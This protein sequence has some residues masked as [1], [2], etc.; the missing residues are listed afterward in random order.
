VVEELHRWIGYSD[1][2]SRGF[3][4]VCSCGWESRP[5]SSA[6]LAAAASDEHRLGL[7]DHQQPG[8]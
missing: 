2:R 4:A 7:E 5:M 3:I 6:G 8:G 1:D